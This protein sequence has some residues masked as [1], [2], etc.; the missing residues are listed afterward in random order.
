MGAIHFSL[1][2]QLFSFFKSKLNITTFVETGTF[3]GDTIANLVNEVESIYSVELS[4]E[5][6]QAAKL[7][8]KNY[9]HVTIVQGD[10]SGCLANILQET[11][12]SATV[13]WLD[14]HWC[15]ASN[16]AG[17]ESQCPLLEELCTFSS[18][19]SKSVIV[20]DDARLF[21]APPSREHR[22]KDWPNF[23]EIS[24]KL[25]DI[26]VE[27]RLIV[28]NDN[29][30]LYPKSIHQE[31]YLFA[32]KYGV[33][34]L[35]IADKSR[36]YDI[37]LKQLIEKEGLI[38]EQNDYI[39]FLKNEN[40]KFKNTES[41][42]SLVVPT[43][44]Q[45]PYIRKCLESLSTQTYSNIEVII[46]DALST[47]E[48]EK[49]C[50]EFAYVDSRFKYFREKDAGQSDAL[51]RGLEK[52]RGRYWTWICSD[53]FYSS[54]S[55]IADLVNGL[56]NYESGY[57]GVFGLAN[58]VDDEGRS[59]G[60]YHTHKND[61]SSSLFQ[62]SWPFSQPASLLITSDVK[63]VGGVDSSL[64]L[65]M[66]LDLFIK[67]TKNGKKFKFI[68]SDIC[69]V[70]IQQNSK[71]VK[72]RKETA[73]NALRVV[74]SHFG[75]IGQF[76]SSAYAYELKLVVGNDEALRLTKE[77]D[78]KSFLFAYLRHKFVIFGYKYFPRLI[79]FIKSNI[80]A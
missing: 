7:R 1:H 27:H 76:N 45:G 60:T 47:D 55:A 80:G 68:N 16:T 67:L 50:K 64:Y 21:L 14:A 17:L 23:H 78:F 63:L 8:F 54:S 38:N 65:G 42:V 5:L 72:F 52:S 57:T 46:Q 35:T 40:E 9:K 18:L 29:I 25:L 61:V 44:N 24:K 39:N 49:I 69:S 28:L 4:D 71:S 12:D 51:N 53:D 19:N 22:P 13:Y 59:I 56:R 36:D 37:L 48:T 20:I 34:W 66:D 6:A 70:R 10:S 41:L 3:K 2:D 11:R 31:M 75:S 77:I 33:D 15:D 32:Q 62:I 73:L 79:L 43:Y 74:K 26:S 30:I 58:Y